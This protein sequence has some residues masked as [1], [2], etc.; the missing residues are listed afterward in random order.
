MK[1]IMVGNFVEM[2]FAFNGKMNLEGWKA[3]IKQNNFDDVASSY[4]INV[5]E[6]RGYIK[7]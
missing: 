4:I 5:A 3:V 6:V 2:I 7:K 1:K